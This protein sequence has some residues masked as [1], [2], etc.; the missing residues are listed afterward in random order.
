MFQRLL[1]FA[2]MFCCRIQSSKLSGYNQVKLN[3]TTL[4][5]SCPAIKYTR[6]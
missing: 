2:G 6:C 3:A 1:T 4:A 5:T